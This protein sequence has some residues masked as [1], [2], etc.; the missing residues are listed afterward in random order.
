MNRAQ[1]Y[2]IN[3]VFVLAMVALALLAPP[4]AHAQAT[5]TV[6]ST[7]QEVTQ[8]NPTGT[9]NGN[10]TLGE[11]ILAANTNAAVDGCAAGSVAGPDTIIVPAGIYTLAQVDF[12]DVPGPSS[13]FL[14]LPFGLPQIVSN[15]IITGAGAATTSIERSTAGGTPPFAFLEIH[16]V[17]TLTLNNLT[18]RN[19][20]QVNIGN[21][22]FGGA[23]FNVNGGAAALAINNCVFDSNTAQ[24]GGAIVNGA[25][26]NNSTFTNN[27]ASAGGGAISLGTSFLPVPP[28]LIITNSTFSSNNASNGGAISATAG[29]TAPVGNVTI[30]HSVFTNNSAGSGGALRIDAPATASIDA[31]IFSGNQGEGGAIAM[32]SS[33]GGTGGSV[34]ISNSAFVN[35]Q[36]TSHGGAIFA[37]AGS[38]TIS[39]STFSGNAVASGNGSAIATDAQT[40]LNN[41]TIVNNS[42]A[43]VFGEGISVGGTLSYSNTIIAGNSPTDTTAQFGTVTSLGFNIIGNNTSSG[44]GFSTVASDQAGTGA[45]PIN[46]LLGGLANNG[47]TV[48]AGSN[49][50]GQTPQVVQTMALLT[51][52][53]ALEKGNPG[54][55]LDGLNGHCAATDQ[56]GNARPGGTLCDVGAFEDTTGAGVAP[57]SDFSIT[58]TGAPGTLAVGQNITF[59]ITVTNN[60]PDPAAGSFTD[61]LPASFNFVSLTSPA[62]WTCT[63]PAV[64][65]S[66][67]VTCSH[68]GL[69]PGASGAFTLVVATTAGGTIGNTA[70]VSIT[71]NDPNSANN[72][73][74]ATTTVTAQNADMSVTKS[75]PV[76][77]TL[78]SGNITYTVLV[79]NNGPAGATNVVL[80][81]TLPAG[82]TFV[83]VSP[84]GPVCTQAAG[85]VTCNLGALISGGSATVTIIVTPTTAG[86][87]LNTASVSAT[88]P[89][90]T[91]ANNTATA[92]TTVNPSADLAVTKT[93]LPDPV[94]VNA[95]LT[96]TITVTNNGPSAA[97]SASLSDA[98]TAGVNFVSLTSAAGWTCTTP[99][100][101]ANGTVSCTNPSVGSGVSG[102]FTLIVTPTAAA[103]ASISNTATVSATTSDPN[104]A[105]NSA[106][107]QTTVRPLADLSITKTDTPDPV[108]AGS[109]ITYTITVTNNGPSTATSVSVT[110]AV[111]ANVLFNSATGSG[112]ATCAQA[113]GT[114]TCTLASLASGA[115]AS[116]TVVMQTIA[117]G[118]VTNTVNVTSSTTDPNA[119][120]NS[121][122]ATTT[123]IPPPATDFSLAVVPILADVK[124]G[125]TGQFTLTLAAVP[126]GANFTGTI[127]F[128]C[129]TSPSDGLCTFNPTSVTPGQNQATVAMSV[130]IPNKG[131]APPPPTTLPPAPWG[132]LAVCAAMGIALLMMRKRHPSLR[133]RATALVLVV[134]ALSLALGQAGCASAGGFIGPAQ[135]TVT[136]TSGS[137]SHSKTVVINV[138]P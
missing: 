53:P 90:P 74:T 105:N 64:G 55:P 96:Y 32:G 118:T 9:V 136:A 131:L 61:V 107:A 29:P 38:L 79:T 138:T 10:C 18:F 82:V 133:A 78:G 16:P 102:V 57:Q 47:S 121:A 20:N 101:G 125:G 44:F 69:Q 15:I 56:R 30:S 76:S 111:P 98:L 42:A 58:K 130:T 39:N 87:S 70:S 68:A 95:N 100:V 31:S 110:D 137:L 52:S 49:V 43:S 63:T 73:A 122:T 97:A 65:A 119:A 5:I 51:G 4:A 7:A 109:N 83:S 28:A 113:A 3:S 62:G 1:S 126:A 99:A 106:S 104:A 12:S 19:G 13:P 41:V 11:A 26:I 86:T 123:V 77:I 112:G 108:A 8:A 21:G 59:T 34:T 135:V 115:S 37:N 81:D 45:N 17:G 22:A 24:N 60:G 91:P 75:G 89:D 117:L 116:A 93:D 127:S 50:G 2:T 25:T 66:G 114:I 92:S 85:V 14:G 71:G 6:N 54:T 132:L 36:T 103:A 23:I 84:T 40:S 33:G 48:M 27:T 80:T 46:P 35:N 88:E 128:A 129:F 94:N 134:L 67:T 72:S 124:R 120:N